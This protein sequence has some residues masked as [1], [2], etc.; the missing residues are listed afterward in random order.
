MS[1]KKKQKKIVHTNFLLDKNLIFDQI[2]L[3][4]TFNW[5]AM[6]PTDI[7]NY[8]VFCMQ[9]IFF[10]YLTFIY[11]KLCTKK[12]FDIFEGNSPSMPLKILKITI[13]LEVTPH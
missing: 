2:F 3:P 6:G 4:Q 5:F 7:A 13:F 11:T 9:N 12:E 10:C 1:C 8:S